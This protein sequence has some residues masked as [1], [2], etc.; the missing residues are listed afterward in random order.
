MQAGVAKGTAAGPVFL[1][2]RQ[3]PIHR[4]F[5]IGCG[6]WVRRFGRDDN[7][8]LWANPPRLKATLRSD[9]AA[10]KISG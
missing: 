8:A 4:A 3:G 1:P 10:D 5:E 6:V 2:D 9:T 7:V